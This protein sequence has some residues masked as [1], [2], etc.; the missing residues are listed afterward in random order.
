APKVVNQQVWDCASVVDEFYAFSAL[1]RSVCTPDH[2]PSSG[3]NKI[4][5]PATGSLPMTLIP[6]RFLLR[7]SY[8]CHH[9]ANIPLDDDD[10][11]LDLSEDYRI[12]N[13]A[14]MDGQANFAD[15]RLAWNEAG[16]GLQVTVT[17]KEAPP[18]GNT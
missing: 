5:S 10:T 8:P 11:L 12:D 9:A 18:Q 7:F 14:A 1:R 16:L 6:H 3:Y 4:I 13:L 17:G 15:V 2:L